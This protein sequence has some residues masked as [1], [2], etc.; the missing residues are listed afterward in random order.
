MLVE[1]AQGLR[2]T[3]ARRAA[4]SRSPSLTGRDACTLASGRRKVGGEPSHATAHLRLVRADAAGV[5]PY[6]DLYNKRLPRV[7]ASPASRA[8]S[9]F[10]HPPGPAWPTEHL[11]PPGRVSGRAESL[12]SR[13]L[14]AGPSPHPRAVGSAGT[15]RPKAALTRHRAGPLTVHNREGARDPHE[16]FSTSSLT[17]QVTAS[18]P[19][20]RQRPLAALS[21]IGNLA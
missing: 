18:G 14:G 3:T 8:G 15:S 7:K 16:A 17:G 1:D 6:N 21:V 13:P 9:L 20:D 11:L 5:T 4:A 10:G 12:L 19:V 2:R